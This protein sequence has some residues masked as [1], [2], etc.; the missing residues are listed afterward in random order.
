MCNVS[1]VLVVREESGFNLH[2]AGTTCRSR[3]SKGHTVLRGIS[4]SASCSFKQGGGKMGTDISWFFSFILSLFFDGE[5]SLVTLF[6]SSGG[7]AQGVPKSM[8][9]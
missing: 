4:L 8:S 2:S 5:G 6:D 1:L 3:A 9:V 7:K